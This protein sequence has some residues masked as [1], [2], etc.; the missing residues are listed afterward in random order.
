VSEMI[1]LIVATMNKHNWQPCVKSWTDG[2]NSRDNLLMMHNDL[3]PR[4]ILESYNA[5]IRQGRGD[6]LLYAHDDLICRDPNWRE[7][8]LGAFSDPKVQVVG[9]AGALGHGLPHIYKDPFDI[10]H[11]SRVD[12]ISN[13]TDAEV[14]GRRFTGEC[15]VSVLDGIALFVRRSWMESEIGYWPE[16]SPAGYWLYAEWLCCETRRAGGKIKLVGLPVEHLGGQT[17]SRVNVTDDFQKAHEWLYSN[18]KDVLPW[19]V[20]RG[21]LIK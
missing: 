18:Y 6:I 17:S 16:A 21:G 19:H 20:D 5:A 7:R 3:K 4:T 13:M 11:L 10:P 14:H 2:L 15:E 8:I 12:F 9:V 1:D